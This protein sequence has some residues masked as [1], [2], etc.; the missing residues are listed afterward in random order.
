M[1][2]DP[3]ADLETALAEAIHR[4]RNDLHAVIAMLRLQANAAAD[5]LV[6]TALLA[7]EARVRALSNLN[8]RLDAQGEG[9]E[10]TIGSVSFLNGLA[11]DLRDMHFGQRPVALDVRAEPHRIALVHAKPLGLVLNELVVNALKYAFPGG[12]PGT[13]SID[14]RG[15]GSDY[16]LRVLDDGIGIDPAAPPQGTGLG[17][18]MVTALTSQIAGTFE[19]RPGKDGIGTECTVR[20]PAG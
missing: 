1:S 10:T 6:R 13:V 5:P 17:G 3:L 20:W 19:I 4:A 16:L 9:L 14:F 15:R 18:R 11:T 2:E 8:A 7:A 12:R